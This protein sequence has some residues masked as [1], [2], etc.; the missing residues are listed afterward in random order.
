[1]AIT[2]ALAKKTQSARIEVLSPQEQL[3]TFKLPEGFVM[4]L[5]ASEEDGIVNPIDM[6]FDDKGRLWTQTARMYPLDPGKDIGWNQ[7]LKLMADPEALKKDPELYAE[8][9]RIQDLYQGTTKGEDKILIVSNLYGDDKAKVSDFA[10][11]L[12]IPQTILPYKNGVYVAQ[13]SE[14]F[15][16]DDTNGDGVADKRTPLVT[17]FGYTDT[18]TMT[19]T[20]VRGPGNWIHFSQGALN[21]G[22]ATAVKSGAKARFALL[23]D[24]TPFHRW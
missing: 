24:R 12:A 13:G 8:F 6:A 23:E 9:K 20:F 4:E 18:H 19:H 14:M 22:E 7:L 21:M 1:M 11:G 17:G 3:K 10:D 2:P 5:V 16:L 15:F